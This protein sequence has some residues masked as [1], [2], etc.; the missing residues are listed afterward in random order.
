M[1]I[2]IVSSFLR[3]RKERRQEIP[4]RVR[5]RK[6][7]SG[8]R[9]RFDIYAFEKNPIEHKEYHGTSVIASFHSKILTASS[10]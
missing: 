2:T 8:L 4:C 5:I 7:R 10:S 3:C 9:I 1:I 6:A